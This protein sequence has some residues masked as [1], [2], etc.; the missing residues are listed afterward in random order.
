M[1]PEQVRGLPSA[2][3]TEELARTPRQEAQEAKQEIIAMMQ[4]ARPHSWQARAISHVVR[5]YGVVLPR[6]NEFPQDYLR[7]RKHEEGRI[8]AIMKR[9]SER[10]TEYETERDFAMLLIGGYT[11]ARRKEFIQH[12]AI[13]TPNI[14]RGIVAEELKD[15][16]TLAKQNST[17]I[18]T[19]PVTENPSK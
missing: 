18:F 9:N 13:P 17:V 5:W 8:E 2:S 12:G 7:R 10:S 19:R 11:F 4:E 3:P 16:K 14:L 6:K 15:M 1:I